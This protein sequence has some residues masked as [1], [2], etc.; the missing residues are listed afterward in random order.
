MSIDRDIDRDAARYRWLRRR[1]EVCMVEAVSGSKRPGL[2]VR[3]GCAFLDTEP[4]P[5]SSDASAAEA[6][7]AAIDEAMTKEG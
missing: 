6:L 4:R 1:I 2:E 7:D 3:L 5:R